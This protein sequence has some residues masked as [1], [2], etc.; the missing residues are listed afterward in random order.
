EKLMNFLDPHHGWFDG[1]GWPWGRNLFVSELYQLLLDMPQI[2]AVIPSTDAKGSSI[3]ELVVESADRLR[4]NRNGEVESVE[5]SAHELIA[6][7]I[8][9]RDI[10]VLRR[11]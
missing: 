9:V 2:D 1:T 10:T 4:R 3:D 11:A 5:L 6:P 7:K 8:D